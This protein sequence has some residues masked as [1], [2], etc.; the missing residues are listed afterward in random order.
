MNNAC[1]ATKGNGSI[2]GKPA[3]YEAEGKKY[4]GIH[5]KKFTDKV[6][7]AGPSKEKKVQK[8][9]IESSTAIAAAAAAESPILQHQHTVID[10]RKRNASNK[11]HGKLMISVVE[12]RTLP[13][14]VHG[15]ERIYIEP[16]YQSR[17]DGI[18]YS[19][20]HPSQLGPVRHGNDK[21]P[22]ART[23]DAYH[24][25]NMVYKK[26]LKKST[27]ANAMPSIDPSFY[28]AQLI[29]YKDKEPSIKK[30]TGKMEMYVLYIGNNE[31]HIDK[32]GAREVFCKQYHRLIKNTDMFLDL[33]QRTKLGYNLDIVGLPNSHKLE[34]SM[35]SCEQAFKS[36]DHSFL[37][38]QVLFTVLLYHAKD[39]SESDLPWNKFE[40]LSL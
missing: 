1:E 32:Q 8:K 39:H 19:E 4:C 26:D 12:G 24:R 20:L 18:C 29:G 7:L 34:S 23:L 25:Y 35:K 16:K 3:K 37:A 11:S 17:Q 13:D 33:L 27:A 38:A 36:F 9:V 40:K 21:F 14:L 10:A 5:A 31:L 15:Y 30:G 6:E 2:C 22:P 28:E